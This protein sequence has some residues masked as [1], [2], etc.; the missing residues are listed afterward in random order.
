MRAI[1]VTGLVA[2]FVIACG[3]PA[4]SNRGDDDPTI[5]AS[6]DA[7]TT[8]WPQ[9]DGAVNGCTKLDL[10]FVVDDSGSMSE[11]QT[12]L[13]ANFPTF[14]SVLDASGLDYRVA[15]TTTSRKYSYTMAF[16]IG[17]SIP[18]DTGN[19]DNGAMRQPASCNMTRRWIEKTDPDKAATFACVANVGTGGN[20]DE[21]P[22]GAMRDAFE[23]RMMDATNAGFRRADA[24][25]GIVLLTDEEDCSYEA[26]VNLGFTESL[27]ES[28]MEPAAN[29]VSFLDAYT[30]HRSRWAAAAIAG[31]G[32]GSCTS[33]F[34]S[35]AEATRLAAFVQQAGTQ[36]R[37]SSICDGDLSVSLTQTLALF[38]SACGA[39]IF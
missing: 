8:S 36:A 10:L 1:K 9:S 17:G 30:G 12:N 7:D 38:Q 3:P 23:E 18:M 13:V 27:C 34:G 5:D 2:T 33:A 31:V 22:L 37:M 29:Y 35:A 14:I 20:S 11:E 32:P 28:Q 15:V 39:V 6:V 16:P 4:A 26:P 19:G 21:M 24:L 25:L